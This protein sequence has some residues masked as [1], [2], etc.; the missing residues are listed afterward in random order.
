[1]PSRHGRLASVRYALRGLGALL[2]HEPNAR[3]HLV[4]TV[5]VVALGVVVRLAPLEWCAVA[6]AIGMVWMAEALNTAVEALC[7][8]VH[9]DPH[10]LVARAKDV[11]AAGVLCAALGAATIGVLVFGRRLP[12]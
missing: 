1:M 3:L 11:A 6:V 9:P 8:L 10:P 4:A 12:W 2:R 5:V 7:D